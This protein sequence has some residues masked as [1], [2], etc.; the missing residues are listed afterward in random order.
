MIVYTVRKLEGSMDKSDV[1]NVLNQVYDPDYV[2]RSVVDMGLVKKRDITIADNEIKIVYSLTASMCPF[3]AALGL[4][5]KYALEKKLN[6]P[7]VINLTE[8]HYQN[9]KVNEIL[10]DPQQCQELMD[11][12]KE[13]GIIERCIRFQDKP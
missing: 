1:M 13:F 2:N 4:M 5:M 11:K 7:V 3:S 8:G 10:K 6:V 12:L 9:K